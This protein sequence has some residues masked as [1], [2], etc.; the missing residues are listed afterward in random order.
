M[1]L[2]NKR[3]AI[4]RSTHAEANTPMSAILLFPANKLSKSKRVAL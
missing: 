1:A 4:R 3:I 2:D